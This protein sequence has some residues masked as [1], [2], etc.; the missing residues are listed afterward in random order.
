MTLA[1]NRK[2]IEDLML[3]DS[4]QIFTL[5]PGTEVAPNS[6]GRG[7]Y[8]NDNG[9]HD[10]YVAGATHK[11]RL[12]IQGPAGNVG[13]FSRGDYMLT[14]NAAVLVV[15]GNVEIPVTARVLVTRAND[16]QTYFA[17]ILN[18]VHHTDMLTRKYALQEITNENSD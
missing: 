5:V 7:G 8:D 10:Q 18:S 9:A 16:S 15:P 17:E 3:T 6:D 2:I 1:Q 4:V 13:E 11:C 12:L 14:R